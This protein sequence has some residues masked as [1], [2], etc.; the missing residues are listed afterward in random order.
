MS[1]DYTQKYEKYKSKY[2]S[3]KMG[4]GGGKS[5]NNCLINKSDKVLFGDGGSTAI[6]AITQD[7]RVFKIFTKY[8][9]SLDDDAKKVLNEENKRNLTEIA[10]YKTL[11]K[12]IID[13]GISNHFV[14]YLGQ[15]K[16]SNAKK[17]FEECPTYTEFIKIEEKKKKDICTKI[18]KGFPTRKLDSDYKVVEIEYCD[19]SCSDF[20]KDV[21]KLS[22]MD[23]EKYLDIF[24]FQIVHA[25]MSVQSV[26]PYF[27][28]G[29]LFMRNILGLREKDNGNYYEYTFGKKSYFVPKKRFYPKI[30]DFG[31]TNINK[32][33]RDTKLYKSDYKDIYNIMFDVYNGGNLGAVSLSELCK[34][35]P[36]KLKFLKKYFS[37]FFD[38]DVVDNYKENSKRNMNWDWNNVLDESFLRSINMKNPKELLNGYFHD[39]FGK[40]NSM[41]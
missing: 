15:T 13:K 5:R 18:Y 27:V 10:I 26:Y 40:I 32:N 31:M 38:V 12:D 28:H 6:I 33:V 4:E 9:Y 39:V 37:N 20:I 35:N 19:Y 14:K 1:S 7:K 30:N 25:V 34:E 3:M 2:L 29:D 23:M 21:S 17:L 11:T 41:V 24:F 22:E 16:C 8:S 36:D